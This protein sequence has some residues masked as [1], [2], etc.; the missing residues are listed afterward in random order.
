MQDT[1]VKIDLHI[2]S[3]SSS[4]Y[5]GRK[6]DDEYLNIL[7]HAKSKKLNI[8]SITDHNSI[9][10]Y[11]KFLQIKDHLIAQR[12]NIN[13]THSTEM[14]QQIK[15]VDEK[16]SLFDD[17]LILPGVEFEVN[18]GIHLLVI[19]SD[20]TPAE[21]IEQF[22]IEGGYKKE[23][24]GI[25]EPS[26]I[27]KWDIFSLFEESK[28]Y[29]C[30]IIDAHTDS[31]KGIL[32]TIPKGKPRAACFKSEQLNG[33]CY[34]NEK[35]R[36]NLEAT[37]STS[38]DYQRNT[39]LAFVKFSDA[40]E[41]RD[42]GSNITFIKLKSLSFEALRSAFS[43]P[44]ENISIE[45]PSLKN[46]L[47]N[48]LQ[49]EHSYG[50]IDIS[51]DS[52][53]L[54]R[55]YIC[56]LHNSTGGYILIGVSDRKIIVGLTI[57]NQNPEKDENIKKLLSSLDTIDGQG[58]SNITIY[59]LQDNKAILS[60]HIP[61]GKHLINLKGQGDIYSF[62]KR[63]LV[64]LSAREIE[65]LI[66]KKCIAT[67]ESKIS[68]Q[69]DA[70][71]RE[72]RSARY[73][74]LSIPILNKF[75]E[76]STPN[77][78]TPEIFS[79]IK[80]SSDLSHAINN[81]NAHGRSRGNIFTMDEQQPPRLKYA[82]LRYSLPLWNIKNITYVRRT[83]DIIY[84]VPGGAVFFSKKNVPFYSEKYPY[85]I[86][87][88]PTRELNYSAKFATC[89]LKSSFFIW[90]CRRTF[91]DLDIFRPAIFNDIRFPRLIKK[92]D[93]ELS[94]FAEEIFD[95]ILLQESIFL[96]DIYKIKESE[97][98]LKLIEK[99]NKV[100]D[101]KAHEIDKTIYSLLSLTSEEASIIENDLI[102]N[103]IY[104]PQSRNQEGL[105]PDE[106][107]YQGGRT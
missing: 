87:A 96:K 89:F 31:D 59:E 81:H 2:H 44:S 9:E 86:R 19:F 97:Q 63:T 4:C 26:I 73:F 43:N 72:C 51:D 105:V 40:H 36:A 52:I 14:N 78:L 23:F 56:A 71:E 45:E 17:I 35:Q 30:I 53:N 75:E 50:I 99:H 60:F 24:Y 95:Q 42:V 107:K 98:K 33:V 74:F 82:Y 68:R 48:L 29:E 92:K 55:K 41:A 77:I 83:E 15:L 16:L 10:G 22:L 1:F 3:P 39:S 103:E 104:L 62:D 80:L 64:T 32:N 28:K 8:I 25:E 20:R 101:I 93:I 5:K 49:N 6:D 11:K 88:K 84:I 66:E 76:K 69:I 7:R 34:K 85:V 54:L 27:P 57:R 12:I 70:V 106:K 38:L 13:T 37:L 102:I 94:K 100:V 65:K 79:S 91:D 61:K 90:F 47:N 67:L 46:I 21:K 58:S 18:N